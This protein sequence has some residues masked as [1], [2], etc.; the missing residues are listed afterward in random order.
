MTVLNI[1]R[2]LDYE[3]KISNILSVSISESHSSQTTMCV[4]ECDSTTYEIGDF[5][6]LKEEGTNTI[7]FTGYVKEITKKEPERIYTITAYDVLIRAAD[8]FIASSTP[9]NPFKR[10]N[11]A[12]ED[13]VSD[14]LNLA[15]LTLHSYDPTSFTFA[16]YSPLEV[17]LVSAYDYCKFIADLLTW[18]LYADYLGNIHFVNRKPY[19]MNGDSAVKTIT[20]SS[21][22]SINYGKTDKDL[23]NRVVVYGSNGV[24]AE[25]SASSPYLPSGYYKTVVVAAPQVFDS[26]SMAEQAAA[27]NLALFN[28]LTYSLNM[29]II[30]DLHLH[31]RSI[32]N[33]NYPPIGINNEL[34][35]VYS[36]EKRISKT[37]FTCE[38]ELRK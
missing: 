11:I 14:I 22:L 36:I 4:V 2:L 8:F 26:Q 23:R 37:G 24:A 15:G 20:G 38:L 35:Y 3:N 29:E 7:V 25:A 1:S 27:Y 9:T 5:F 12:A 13:L 31:A 6:Q 16:I 34:W 33:I 19:I 17:N 18:H 21:M 10:S 32:V 30:G 28:R